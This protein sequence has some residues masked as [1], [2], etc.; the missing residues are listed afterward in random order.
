M[1][2]DGKVL[3]GGRFTTVG[4]TTRNQ[5]ARRVNDAATQTLNAPGATQV[6]WTR[7]GSS[8]EVSS[9]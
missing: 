1:Q 6:I 7:G 5:C 3:L 2:A 9:A 4:G 8:P